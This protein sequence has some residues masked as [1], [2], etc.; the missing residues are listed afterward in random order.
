MKNWISA[1]AGILLTAWMAYDLNRK[2]DWSGGA[3]L[4]PREYVAKYLDMAYTRGQ[5][6]AAAK[7]FFAPNAV[8][9][10][11]NAVD[12]LDGA[13]IVHRISAII[14]DGT[15]VAVHHRIDATRGQPALDV[16]DIYKS[17][18]G[19]ITERL[20]IAQPAADAG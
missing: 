11:P 10:L 9:H 2:F 12:R 18:R 6:A 19:K 5:G 15:T 14:A 1:V 16:V 13:P 7:E 20:R 8:D 3:G 17:A 4:T